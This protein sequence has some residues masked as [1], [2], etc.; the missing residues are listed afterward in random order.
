MNCTVPLFSNVPTAIGK[1]WVE[2]VASFVVLGQNH[3]IQSM[4]ANSEKGND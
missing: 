1:Q 4:R 2:N 3:P